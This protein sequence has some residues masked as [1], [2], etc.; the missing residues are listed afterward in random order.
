MPSLSYVSLSVTFIR[1]QKKHTYVDGVKNGLSVKFCRYLPCPIT[2]ISEE[3]HFTKSMNVITKTGINSPHCQPFQS[4]IPTIHGK[5][6]P[7]K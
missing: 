2:L 6:Y 7:K 3:E 4:G 1:Q 5:P